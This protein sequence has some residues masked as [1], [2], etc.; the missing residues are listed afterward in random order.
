[1]FRAIVLLVLS[2]SSITLAQSAGLKTETFDHDPRWDGYRNRLMPNPGPI[3]H[4]DFGLDGDRVGGWIQRSTT[5]ATF[6]KI[7]PTKTLNDHLSASGRFTMPACDGGSSVL[8]G[9][10]NDQSRGWRT[11]NSLFIHLDGNGGKYWVFFEYGTQHWLTGGKGTFQGIHWQTTKT[12]PF[13]TGDAVHTWKLDYDPHANNDLGLIRLTLDGQN[14]DLP[15]APGHKADGAIFNRFGLM[16]QQTT[17]RHAEVYFDHLVIDGQEQTPAELSHWVGVGNRVTFEDHVFRPYQDFGF[18][19]THFASGNSGEIGGVVWRDEKASYYADR[20]GPLSLDSELYASGKISFRGASSDSGVFIGWFNS[21]MRIDKTTIDA[22]VRPQDI[23]AVM[24][25]GPSRI[26]HYFRPA[27]FN[28]NSVGVIQDSGPIIRPDGKVHNWSIH[29]DPNANEDNGSIV[30][31]LDNQ[32]FTT[33]L[34][35]GTKSPQAIFDH[36]GIFD[37]MTGGNYVQFY[38]DDLKYTSK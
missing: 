19:D 24:I 5:P 38:L 23:L 37:I 33:N 13:K 14:Y 15:L 6:A 17:G 32:S 4:Q 7:I 3:T 1:M 28:E 11:P 25:E 12:K 22:K 27:C 18:S 31:T 10:F 16:N 29:Y 34:P 21:Q 30:V 20:V 26:G 9:W 2:F 35:Q 36:F 8:F